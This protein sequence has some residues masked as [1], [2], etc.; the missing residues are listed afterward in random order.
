MK[1]EIMLGILL[2]LLNKKTASASYLAEKFEVSIRSIYRY[3]HCIELAGVPIYTIRGAN[4]GFGIVDTYKINSTFMTVNEFEQVIDALSA[5]NDGVPD[6]VLQSAI[7]KLKATVKNEFSGFDIK[8][9]NLIIDGGPWGDSQ[10]YKSKLLVIKECIENKT[11]LFIR[12]HDREG[13][14]TERTIDPYI[15][16]FKQG[17]WY[18]YA[19][20]N[21]RKTFR[22]FKTGRIESATI[23]KSTFIRQDI[24][25]KELP[26]DF[27]HNSTQTRDVALQIDPRCLSDAEEWLGIENVNIEQG[28]HIARLKLPYDDG[29]VSKIMSYGNGIKVLYPAELKQKIKDCAKQIINLYNN[30]KNIEQNG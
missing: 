23:L 24:S 25:E 12:Y 19:Y 15:I 4:G 7:T 2:E 13:K 28:K 26:L 22:F 9:G 21:L 27:W 10:G 20:C 8:S 17:L 6:K 1:Y 16:V 5:I 11:Q 3:I 14:I 18:V 30:A 29:L